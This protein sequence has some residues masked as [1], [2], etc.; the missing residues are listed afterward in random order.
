MSDTQTLLKLLDRFVDAGNTLLVIEHDLVVID[1][2]PDGGRDG[3]RLLFTG[4][5]TPP[6]KALR[7]DLKSSPGN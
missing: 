2:R 4:T 6:P 7:D 1:L 3:G 5:P